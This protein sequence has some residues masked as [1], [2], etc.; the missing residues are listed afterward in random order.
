MKLAKSIQKASALETHFQNRHPFH[1]MYKDV[2]D[3]VEEARGHFDLANVWSHLAPAGNIY[4]LNGLHQMRLAHCADLQSQL[5]DVAEE[6]AELLG[7]DRSLEERCDLLLQALKTT[8]VG[9]ALG[10]TQKDTELGWDDQVLQTDG[11][12]VL[13][14]FLAEKVGGWPI[15]AP[16]TPSSWESWW[17][18]QLVGWIVALVQTIGPVLVVLGL[19]EGNTNYLHD[20][21]STWQRLSVSSILCPNRPLSDWCTILM[22]VMFSFFVVVQLLNYAASELEDVW[23]YGRLAGCTSFWSIVGGYINAWCVLW[24]IVA[25]PL[26]FWRMER[27]TDVIL[28]SWGLLFMFN[29]DDLTGIAGQVL[30]SNDLEF[31]RSLCWTYAL[32]S[33]CPVELKDVVNP[34][35]QNVEELWSFTL[36][37]ESIR[38]TRCE[39]QSNAPTRVAASEKTPLLAKAAENRVPSMDNMRAVMRFS[40]R[41]YN[42]HLP[43]NNTTM[44][45]SIWQLIVYWLRLMQVLLPLLFFIVN[46]PCPADGHPKS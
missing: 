25:L 8:K 4:R 29:L 37:D 18:A 11:F 6:R 23:K 19:W 3:E 40:A 35:A 21:V 46:K 17:S 28:G 26:S 36:T 20:P 24:N 45:A 14:E 32:L 33:Q 9:L 1:L 5:R 13:E 38:S 2:L 15:V 12:P 16:L 27:A 10:K 41:G 7:R 34:E 22:G 39:D 43:S 44:L 31:Q 42:Y 30:G